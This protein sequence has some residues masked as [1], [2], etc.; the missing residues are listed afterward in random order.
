M[1]Q[2][3]YAVAHVLWRPGMNLEGDFPRQLTLGV[4]HRDT[5]CAVDGGPD[6]VPDGEDLVV[7]PFAALHGLGGAVVPVELAAP[8]FVVEL[9]PH[10]GA[11]IRLVAMCLAGGIRLF[12][13][14]LDPGVAIVRRQ[15]HVD[16]QE[17]I[18]HLNFRPDELVPRHIN[19]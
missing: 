1:D 10:A 9:A 12:R 16:H 14:K 11:D 18:F 2:L 19:I 7:V 3:P 15:L 4:L 5:E 13:A 6:L 8:V 17:K